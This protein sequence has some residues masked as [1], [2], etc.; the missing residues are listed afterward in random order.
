MNK[1]KIRKPTDGL[2]FISKQKKNKK[3]LF[4]INKSKK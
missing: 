2:K 1:K 3:N 4:F